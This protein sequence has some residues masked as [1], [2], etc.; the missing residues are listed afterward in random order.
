MRGMK[1]EKEVPNPNGKNG[2]PISLAQHSFE[3]A[4]LK[5]LCAQPEPKDTKRPSKKSAKKVVG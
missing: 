5:I 4:L 1:N 2:N 3:D